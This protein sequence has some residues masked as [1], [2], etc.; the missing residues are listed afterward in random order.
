MIGLGAGTRIY[1]RCG[2]TDLRKAFDVLFQQ[3][4]DCHLDAIVQCS[5][6]QLRKIIAVG[7]VDLQRR[8]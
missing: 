7:V 5:F 3:R 4:S 8:G 1:L 6:P 2:V